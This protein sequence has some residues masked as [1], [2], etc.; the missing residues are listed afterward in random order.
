MYCS[1]HHLVSALPNV[2]PYYYYT[3][4]GP[5]EMKT[6]AI[7]AINKESCACAATKKVVQSLRN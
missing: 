3:G 1:F 4:A 5:T 2:M 7:V 6:M